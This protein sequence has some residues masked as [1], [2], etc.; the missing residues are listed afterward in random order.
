VGGFGGGG[1]PDNCGGG[2]GGFGGGGAG[3]SGNFGNATQGAGGGGGS[4]NI[5]EN[6][7]NLAG[8]N[9]DHG[10]VA[11]CWNDVPVTT[12]TTTTTLTPPICGNGVTEAPEQCDGGQCCSG[13]RLN[14][15]NPPCGESPPACRVQS[16]CNG[17]SPECPVAGFAPNASTCVPPDRACSIGGCQDGAC[18]PRLN[19]DPVCLVKAKAKRGKVPV[20]IVKC[21][22][23]TRAGCQAEVRTTA[24]SA[25]LLGGTNLSEA[26]D[27]EVITQPTGIKP[28]KRKKR[29]RTNIRLRLNARGREL[30]TLGNLNAVVVV[31]IPERNSST[32][33]LAILLKQLRRRR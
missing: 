19:L 26:D 15:V 13:C 18:E 14:L 20:V 29:F 9:R 8:T 1:A 21:N 33:R 17:L 5:G 10:Q 32:E 16:Q 23:A 2:G 3:G 31:T 4:L 28:K 11:I 7:V 30:L 12:P 22:T 27:G 25:A 24:A 6:Q